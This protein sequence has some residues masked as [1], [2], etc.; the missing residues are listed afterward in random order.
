MG[1]RDRMVVGFMQS[2]PIATNFVS[3]NPFMARCTQ[4]NIM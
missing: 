3:S 1:C 4:S 2:M